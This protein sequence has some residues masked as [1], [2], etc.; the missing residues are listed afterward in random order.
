MDDNFIG[1]RKAVMAFLPELLRWRREHGFPFLFST[2]ATINLADD[3]ALLGMMEAVDFRYVFVGI[4]TPDTD[5][6]LK[7]HRE[8]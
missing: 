4:E 5:L 1:N 2:E 3:P 6:L 7:T 8:R